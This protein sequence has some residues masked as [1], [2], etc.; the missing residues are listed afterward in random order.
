MLGLE[1]APNE[2]EIGELSD[3]AVDVFL[4]A[5]RSESASRKVIVT[6]S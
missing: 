4:R 3:H 2:A 5:Y 1:A 6:A